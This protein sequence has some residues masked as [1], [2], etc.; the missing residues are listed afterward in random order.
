[1]AKQP[2]RIGEI[3]IENGMLTEEQLN[4]GLEIQK[5]EGGLIGQILLKKGFV[6]EKDL[7]N[8]LT[9]QSE[10]LYTEQ[11]TP[12]ELLKNGIIIAAISLF[13]GLASLPLS[14]YLPFVK[15]IDYKLYGALMNIEYCLNKTPPA[16][17]DTLLVTIDNETLTSMPHRWP[18]PRSDFAVVI[19]NLINAQ[20]KVIAFDFAFFGKSEDA[21][22]ALLKNALNSDARII[23]ASGVNEQGE[24][25][26]YNSPV[27]GNATFGIVTK[28]QDRDE[29]IRKGIT[30]LVYEESTNQNKGFLSWGMQILKT[31]KNI[32]L[33][34][35][36]VKGD[37]LSFRSYSGEKWSIPVDPETKS[38]LINFR[39]R[40]RDFPKVSFYRLFK[41]D[42]DPA[43]VRNKIVMV[44]IVSSLLQD[45]QH[46]TIGWLPGLTLNA[47]VFLALYTHDFL[48]NMPKYS[49]YIALIIGIIFAAFFVTVLSFSSTAASIF[50]EIILFLI[51]SYVLLLRGYIW[52]YALFPLVTAIFPLI[53]KKLV[54]CAKLK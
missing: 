42:F 22:D 3:L 39:V 36:S 9:K 4:I 38:F 35:L 20:A 11:E 53:A 8:A 44:G 37:T 31:A 54:Y 25:D 16:I 48:R 2:K 12:A 43:L 7:I 26:F 46:T 24:L 49:E 34:S 30:Y 27:S 45:V 28:L 19:D 14:D 6:S 5:K 13:L 23:L 40:T 10:Y 18:Y 29:V 32:D 1:M 52:N 17:K 47:N 41:G 21:Q 50:A 51:F 33:N 15:N